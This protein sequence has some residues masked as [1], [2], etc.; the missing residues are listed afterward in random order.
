[1][2]FSGAADRVVTGGGIIGTVARVDNPEEV[3]VD[4]DWGRGMTCRPPTGGL[5]LTGSRGPP[6]LPSREPQGKNGDGV[7]GVQSGPSP[8]HRSPIDP[9]EPAIVATTAGAHMGRAV[10]GGGRVRQQGHEGRC[11]PGSFSTLGRDLSR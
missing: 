6:I 2:D 9:Q 3:V 11:E 7:A 10:S 1:M 8:R 5:G 4:T